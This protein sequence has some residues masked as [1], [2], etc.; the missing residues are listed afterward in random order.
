MYNQPHA[1]STMGKL[2]KTG[3]TICMKQGNRPG[4]ERN[5]R[6]IDE[7]LVPC[8][9][10]HG[11]PCAEPKILHTWLY[12]KCAEHGEPSDEERRAMVKKKKKDGGTHVE[13]REMKMG[14]GRVIGM[15]LCVWFCSGYVQC[16]VA[17][18]SVSHHRTEMLKVGS[19][20]RPRHWP[21]CNRETHTH[22]AC[23]A[24]PV[25]ARAGE[26]LKTIE[27]NSQGR[28]KLRYEDGQIAQTTTGGQGNRDSPA[29]RSAGTRPSPLWTA[30]QTWAV[31]C[32][33]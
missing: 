4:A 31:K 33:R 25:R 21:V 9:D 14:G 22:T 30:Y 10:S 18:R 1:P 8:A 6:C 28:H 12:Y 7:E 2:Y 20:A 27:T 29:R 16:P 32:Q 13:V 26:G 3:Y 19:S 17:K 23:Y 24:I 11:A 5:M 15:E